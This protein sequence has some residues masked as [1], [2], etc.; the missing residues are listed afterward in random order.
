[1][2][3]TAGSPAA[4]PSLVAGD[5]RDRAALIWAAA[6]LALLWSILIFNIREW[7]SRV[8]LAR[9]TTVHYRR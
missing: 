5:K 4:K 3:K 2:F 8:A 6:I 7:I 9:C 1:M